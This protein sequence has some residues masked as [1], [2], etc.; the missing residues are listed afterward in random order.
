MLPL[1]WFFICVILI[2]GLAYLF[3]RYVVGRGPS[4]FFPGQRRGMMDILAQM[5]LGKDR[6]V[7]LIQVG[8]RFF[9]LGSTATQVNTLAEIT[10][11]EISAWREKERQMGEEGQPMSFTQSLRDV[12]KQRG[13]RDCGD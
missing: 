11:E 13:G 4:G 2:M 10:P 5:P 12:L 9:L 7:I 8:E 6:Q 3:T 1:V